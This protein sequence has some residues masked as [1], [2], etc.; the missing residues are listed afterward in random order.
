MKYWLQRLG[1]VLALLLAVSM[2]TFAAMNFL[3]DPLFNVLGP[4]ALQ[5]DI[6]GTAQADGYRVSL[7]HSEKDAVARLDAPDFQIALI[8]LRLGAGDGCRVFRR[9]HEDHPQVGTLL[10]TGYRNEV[11]DAVEELA[12]EGLNGVCF[13]PID[14]PELLGILDRFRES[15]V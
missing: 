15:T 3:G 14:I 11:T 7:A 9:L 2:L 5:S 13:K 4:D 6:R 1:M 10:I 12:S 8:D